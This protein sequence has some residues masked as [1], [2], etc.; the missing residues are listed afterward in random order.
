MTIT[1]DRWLTGLK[2]RVTLPANNELLTASDL[3]AL[4][5]DVIRDK[6]VPLMMSVNQNYFVTNTLVPLVTDQSHYDIPYRSMGRTLRDLKLSRN[7]SD[8]QDVTDLSL[9]ALEDEHLFATSGVPGFFYFEGDQFVAVPRPNTSSYSFKV[10]YDLEVGTLVQTSDAALVASIASNVVTIT[11]NIPSTMIAGVLVDF[12]KG[13]AGCRT[14]GM[15]V[16]ITNVSTGAG[17]IT[18]ASADDVP[19]SLAAGDWISLA[20]TSPVLQFP[21]EA[22]PLIETLA[23]IRVMHAAGDFE[24]QQLLDQDAMKQETNLLKLLAPRVEGE[25]TKIVNRRGLLRGQGFTYWRSRRGFY[26]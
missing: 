15:D 19:E 5:D 22:A 7:D 14:V 24:A 3:L 21:D 8:D 23:A 17:T 26:V 12:I 2:R 20:Q 18:F 9:L 1:A 13:K 16:A 10:W 4:G 25:P 11:G 6:M